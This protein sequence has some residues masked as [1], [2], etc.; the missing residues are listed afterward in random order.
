[1]RIKSKN[2]FQIPVLLRKNEH[3]K[4]LCHPPSRFLLIIQNSPIGKAAA[5][6]PD[7]QQGIIAGS[8]KVEEQTGLPVQGEKV[9]ADR[10]VADTAP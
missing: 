2:V 8:S 9:E 10:K 3:T 5:C 4:L 1:M 6:L 7:G